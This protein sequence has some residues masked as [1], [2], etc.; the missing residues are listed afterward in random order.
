MGNASDGGTHASTDPANSN[1]FISTTTKSSLFVTLLISFATFNI[2]GLGQH[3]DSVHSKR[4][5]LGIDCKRY[6]VDICA[7]RETKVVEPGVCTL[8][9]GYRLIWFEQKDG[10]HGCLGFVISPRIFDYVVCWKT[11]SDRVSYIDL[12]IP[13]RSGKLVRSRVVNAYAPHKK[14]ALQNP[15]LIVNFYG[16]LGDA[17]SVPSNFECFMLGDFKLG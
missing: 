8:S 9:N 16:Q 17:I 7:V 4:E 2:R 15:H 13:S 11:I 5:D 1:M 12:D 10:R 3:D 6:N 14:L